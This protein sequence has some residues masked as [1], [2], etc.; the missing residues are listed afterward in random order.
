MA[1]CLWY[2]SY[3]SILFNKHPGVSKMWSLFYINK[4]VTGLIWLTGKEWCFN[5]SVWSVLQWNRFDH[6]VLL[7]ITQ[8][9][10]VAYFSDLRVVTGWLWNLKQIKSTNGYYIATFMIIWAEFGFIKP[11]AINLVWCLNH[12]FPYHIVI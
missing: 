10:L 8:E 7:L 2:I 6:N 5:H 12:R 9:Y 11:R 4:N 3:N 1:T